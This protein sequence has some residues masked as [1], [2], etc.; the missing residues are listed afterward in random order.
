[1]LI[2]L[3]YGDGTNA[4]VTGVGSFDGSSEWKAPR[5]PLLRWDSMSESDDQLHVPVMR[6]TVVNGL[7]GFVLHSACWNLLNKAC[8]PTGLSLERL[9]STCESLP[10]P[11]WFNGVSWG[12]DYE[13]L[14][15]LDDDGAY[16]WM[17]RFFTPS[18]A[19]VNETGAMSDPNDA[20]V[21]RMMIPTAMPHFPTI[22][23]HLAKGADPF[24]RFP[25]EICEMILAN[26]R[27]HDALNLRLASRSFLPLFSSLSFWLLRFERDSERGFIYE[28]SE[29][30]RNWDVET[31]LQ[32]YHNS[33]RSL[34]TS[35]ILNRQRTWNLARR[36]ALLIGT[37]LV[38]NNPIQR[39]FD[40]GKWIRI[41]GREQ[42]SLSTIK[43]EEFEGGCHSTTTI[44]MN[45]PPDVIKMGVTIVNAGVWDYVTG[46]RLLGRDGDEH[47]AGY[48]ARDKDIL[49]SLSQLH[50]LRVAM[51]PGGVRALQVVS[52]GQQASE[53]IGNIEGVPQSD[54]LVVGAPILSLSVT[55]DVSKLSRKT[56]RC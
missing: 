25:W 13:G 19:T 33:K 51:G 34:A 40:S 45:V 36:L 10:F 31:L 21:F 28:V 12:H 23:R 14:L 1:M 42:S 55:L 38:S 15:K 20:S 18:I 3:V 47:V 44:C 32:I 43:W 26:V 16:P 8:E 49:Y 52:E 48:V 11:L 39:T 22:T 30:R 50:G 46:I 4:F 6:Q 2:S 27:T 37:P 29:G 5:D 41:A 54:R 9:I 17:E 35:A 24:S 56:R 7:H 53:W